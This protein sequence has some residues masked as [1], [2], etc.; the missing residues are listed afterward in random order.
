MWPDCPA[1]ES[2]LRETKEVETGDAKKGPRHGFNGLTPKEWTSLSRNVLR[3]ISPPREDY[4]LEHGATFPVELAEREIRI[5]SAVGDLVLDPFVGIGSTLIAAKRWNRPGVGIELVPDF[6]R[7]AKGLLKQETLVG[8]APQRVFND[9]CRNLRKYVDSQTVQLVFTSP[10]YA[11]FIRR[12]VA[13]RTKTHKK[14]RIVNENVS[15]VKP[16]SDDPRDFGNL[17]YDAFLEAL[18][19]VMRDLV[20]VMRPGGYNI[21]VVK[22]YRDPQSGKP[23][24]DFHSDLAH[25][26][27]E[28]GFNYHDLIT[29]DQNEDRSLVVL[30]YPSVFYAN[31]NCSF[32]V[33]LRKPNG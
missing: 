23:Y 33:V 28:C 8:G 6:C 13:D 19:P 31:Q 12:S 3:G 32:L 25:V 16:Y 7:T 10:P 30:G 2:S 22:D 1:E 18:R 14:S 5:Y 15:R 17:P 11:N 20:A 21:W 26:G 24:I 4:R 29:W 9:D 27:Q